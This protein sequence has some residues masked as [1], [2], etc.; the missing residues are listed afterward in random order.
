MV[1]VMFIKFFFPLFIEFYRRC[2]NNYSFLRMEDSFVGA[3]CFSFL[4]FAYSLYLY[5]LIYINYMPVVTVR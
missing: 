5:S 2:Y 4:G 3:N 1:F